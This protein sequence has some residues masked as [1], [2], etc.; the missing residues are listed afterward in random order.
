VNNGAASTHPSPLGDS[1]A[2]SRGPI[3]GPEHRSIT[4]RAPNP[5][6]KI[7]PAG[8]RDH[9]S[10][11]LTACQRHRSTGHPGRLMLAFDALETFPVLGESRT[12]LLAVTT[13][14]HH[15]TADIIS[16]VESDVALVA[17]MLRL[18]NTTSGGRGLID[19]VAGA[20]EILSRQDI[21]ALAS[22]GRT[23]DFFGRADTWK[24][25]PARFRLHA[26]ATQHAADRIAACANYPDRERLA[27]TS[28]LHDIGKLVLIRA[29][30]GYP[31]QVHAGASTPEDRVQQE[32]RELGIDHAM[33][34]A[35]VLRR[36]GLPASVATPIE[37]H[38]HADADG[39]AAIIRLADMLAHYERAASVAPGA[40]IQSA[41][42]VGLTTNQLRTL[43]QEPPCSHPRQ[44][45]RHLD[46]SPF[47]H[48]ELE[49]LQQLA[50][51][52]VY[53]KIAR[54]LSL[55][56][57]TIRTHLHNIY[58]KLGVGDRAQAVLL[59]SKN[60]WL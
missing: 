1:L 11:S 27:V 51:G 23:F 50:K 35:V 4:D 42:A 2:V 20:A 29:H 57:S 33:V 17:A 30:P 5:L 13:A 34:G 18:A 9:A 7:R 16:A 37:R 12:R 25:T 38:H 40:M 28:L 15:A 21:Q 8:K 58:G 41:R 22:S 32:R 31:S 47:T 14:D 6:G 49:V 54:D 26:L 36:W 24:S 56:A 55:T 39:E 43:M 52:S 59:A 48:R 44:R 53:K 45:Q 10:K 3:I 46:P 60:G 19:T